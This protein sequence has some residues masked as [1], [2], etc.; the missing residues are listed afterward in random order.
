[1]I[2]INNL[3]AKIKDTDKAILKGVSLNIKPG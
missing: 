1:M 2:E 3:C